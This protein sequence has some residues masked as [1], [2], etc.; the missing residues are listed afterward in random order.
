MDNCRVFQFHHGQSEILLTRVRYLGV[1]RCDFNQT[2]DKSNTF[3]PLASSSHF[4]PRFFP[5]PTA[6]YAAPFRPVLAHALSVT[7]ARY[8]VSNMQH[9]IRSGCTIRKNPFHGGT[10]AYTFG[11]KLLILHHDGTKNSF[12]EHEI[13]FT[14]PFVKSHVSFLTMKRILH[15]GGYNECMFPIQHLFRT[16]F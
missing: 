12:R 16:L 6:L 7:Q 9:S 13:F 8:D 1:V 5:D 15:I 3:L 10:G 4:C 2:L 14:F 11:Y